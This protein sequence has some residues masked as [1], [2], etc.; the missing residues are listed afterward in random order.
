MFAVFA[1]SVSTSRTRRVR[2]A[3]HKMASAAAA[4]SQCDVSY[5]V[6]SLLYPRAASPTTPART[7]RA[8]THAKA[9]TST[10]SHAREASAT[11]VLAL[12][13]VIGVNLGDV[14]TARAL[15]QSEFYIEDIPSGLSASDGASKR[16]SLSSLV[17]G[18]NGKAIEA[19]A[20]KC[21]A[22][23]ARGGSG[24]GAPGLG[25]ISAR[26]DPVIF[27]DGFRSREYCLYECT[28]ICSIRVNAASRAK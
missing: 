14:P 8:R 3:A 1:H 23:C 9:S 10:P 5:M 28:D 11:V 2:C 25:P 19:C 13:A 17:R 26:R 22:T 27:K 16:Q 12:A 24:T 6:Q 20:N 18:P 7:T 15:E 21:L 4:A